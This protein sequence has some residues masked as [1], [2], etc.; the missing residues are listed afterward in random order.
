MPAIGWPRR[1]FIFTTIAALALGISAT[2]AAAQ[3]TFVSVGTGAISGLYYPVARALCDLVNRGRHAHGVRCSAEPTSGSVFN[4]EGLQA[5]DLDL[6]LVQSDVQYAAYQ[7]RGQWQGVPYPGLRSILSLYPELVTVLARS[8]AR[9]G[10]V[11]NLKNK[12]VDIGRTGSGA[13]ATWE[14]IE[15]ALGWTRADLKLAVE[16]KPDSA[17]SALCANQIDA[18]VQIVG[19]P[20]AWLA[21]NLDE[22]DLALVSV[23]GPAIAAL[24]AGRPYYRL[25]EIPAGAYGGNAATPTFG[26]SATLV[27]SAELPDEVAYVFARS[28]IEGVDQLRRVRPALARLDPKEMVRASLTAPLHP[29]AERAYRELGL[30]K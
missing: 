3:I 5:G 21:Q 20:S 6:A 16:L 28:A 4:V 25:G 18:S 12:R 27:A 1:A 30:A 13:H 17:R 15:A 11:E 14:A 24:V 23:A 19:H 9:V 8:D 10:A 2:T 26:V 29:G 7:G 22:C